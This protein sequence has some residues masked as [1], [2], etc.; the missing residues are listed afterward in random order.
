NLLPLIA[1]FDG[2]VV[3][4]NSGVGEVVQTSQPHI[5]FVVADVS[6]LQVELDVDSEDMAEVRV[7]LE[8][9]FQPN[10]SG[11][12]SSGVC[13]RISPEVDATTLRVRV[14]AEIDNPGGR[15]RPNTLGTGRILVGE[16][17]PARGNAADV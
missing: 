2:Q 4:R 10:D 8:V 3:K 14:H 17:R 9:T 6:K 1:P 11:P 12:E 13:S 15:L 16:R 5:L 7:G